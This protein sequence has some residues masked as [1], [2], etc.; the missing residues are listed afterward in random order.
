MII[1]FSG[2]MGSGKSTAVDCLRELHSSEHSFKAVVDIKFAQA[3]YDMQEYI[4]ER[5]SS[6][7]KRPETFIK[8][9]KLLQWLGT[10]WGRGTISETIWVDLWKARV[11]DIRLN[12]PLSI[13]VCDDV[14]FDNEAE[15]IRAL[16][17]FVVRINCGKTD[18]RIDTGAGIAHHAS[19]A[20]IN[21]KLVDYEINNSGTISEFKIAVRNLYGLIE[22]RLTHKL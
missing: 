10:Q 13:V 14:R 22:H 9:R 8:D 7:H 18:K 6:V 20:G 11:K 12:F 15:T 2:N 21:A 16:G 3:L 1:G 4:Y 19:E 17:G 5:I